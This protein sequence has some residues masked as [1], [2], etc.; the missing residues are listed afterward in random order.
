MAK[1]KRMTLEMLAEYLPPEANWIA[2]FEDG[3]WWWFDEEPVL[4]MDADGGMYWYSPRSRN[5]IASV[6]PDIDASYCDSLT[7]LRPGIHT[8][9]ERWWHDEGS[10]MPPLGGEDHSEHVRRLCEIA[11][12]NGAY[13]AREERK[14]ADA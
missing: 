13:V 12:S 9:F 14:S 5:Y 8:R 11:W 10:G 6:I 3:E 1:Q 2:M 7:K 4:R